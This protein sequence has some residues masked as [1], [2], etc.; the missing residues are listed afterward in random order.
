MDFSGKIA[1]VT[2]GS[3]GIGKAA[4]ELLLEQGAKVI[5]LD[6]KHMNLKQNKN[7]LF[8]Y[9]IDVTDEDQI[10]NAIKVIVEKLLP[11]GGFEVVKAVGVDFKL[12]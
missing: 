8:Y 2:G 5:V 1:I 9:E 12:D 10:S 7:N 11:N 6:L 4:V 3:S